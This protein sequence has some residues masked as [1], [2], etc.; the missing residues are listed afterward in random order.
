MFSLLFMVFFPYRECSF[1]YNFFA[2]RK[3][4]KLIV[5]VRKQIHLRDLGAAQLATSLAGTLPGLTPLSLMRVGGEV[6][7]VSRFIL[8]CVV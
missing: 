3:P 1:A 4:T 8:S 5:N 6:L 7:Q 2:F